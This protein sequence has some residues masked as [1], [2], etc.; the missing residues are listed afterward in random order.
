MER[1]TNIFLIVL[2]IILIVITFLFDYF[3]KNGGMITTAVWGISF[4]IIIF[5]MLNPNKSGLLKRLFMAIFFAVISTLVFW[6][7]VWG[8]DSGWKM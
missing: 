7:I 2:G 3:L 8:I 6:F 5:G 1:W 4:A